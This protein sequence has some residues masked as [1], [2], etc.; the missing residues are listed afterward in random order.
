M[1]CKY[2]SYAC[3]DRKLSELIETLWNVNGVPHT[4]QMMQGIELIETL[5][6]VN[7]SF[8]CLSDTRD[9]ELIE[10]LWNVN[11]PVPHASLMALLRN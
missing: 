6:N 8:I 2:N 1:E 5:W 7:I 11:F 9:L 4:R 3:N 10:T